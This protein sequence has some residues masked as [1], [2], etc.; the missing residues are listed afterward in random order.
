[1]CDIKPLAEMKGE[2]CHRSNSLLQEESER[3]GRGGLAEGFVVLNPLRTPFIMYMV[4]TFH[5]KSLAITCV[6][7]LVYV[8]YNFRLYCY[9]ARINCSTEFDED[10][11]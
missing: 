9:S 7:L 10:K 4:P 5:F 2:K 8:L 3:M 1:M 11:T 6:T